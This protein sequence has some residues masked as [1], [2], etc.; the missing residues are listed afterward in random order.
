MTVNITLKDN[1]QD[2]TIHVHVEEKEKE[3]S[4][5]AIKLRAR[6]A[7][8]GSIMITEHPDIDVVIMGEKMKIVAFAK[9]SYED[10]VYTAQSRLFDYLCKKGVTVRESVQGGNVYGS[11][12]AR[13]MTP[14][15][16][17]NVDELSTLIVGKFIM[18]EKP[19]YEF[20]QGLEDDYEERL[21][22]PS[23][24]DSTNLGEIPQSDRNGSI[25]PSAVRRY[26]GGF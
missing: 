25:T 6:R 10:S 2:D 7:L 20:M 5:Y 8:D 13:I 18:E 19:A 24:E 16:K 14:K 1:S 9:S 4:G 12:E 23:D 11:L 3:K 17:M 26:I 15:K 22:S 21:T